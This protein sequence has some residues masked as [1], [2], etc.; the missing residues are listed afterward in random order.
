MLLSVLKII[1][2]TIKYQFSFIFPQ[3]LLRYFCL[4]FTFN[5]IKMLG[6]SL[7]TQW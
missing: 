2:N 3:L 6:A 4:W 1:L 7:V 5:N